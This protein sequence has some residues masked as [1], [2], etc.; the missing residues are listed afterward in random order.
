MNGE[1]FLTFFSEQDLPNLFQIQRD[2]HSANMRQAQGVATSL[3]EVKEW[4][5]YRM[6]IQSSK[7]FIMGVRLVTTREI[8]G[9]VTLTGMEQ[10]L[11]SAEIGIV[12]NEV[13]GRGKGSQALKKLER[14][15]FG[16]FGYKT[17]IVNVLTI[18]VRALSFFDKH[19]YIKVS[20]N[21]GHVMLKK[22]L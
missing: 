19:A 16:S 8:V 6:R 9:Y 4:L 2:A 3:I 22:N 18:N 1:V 13:T 20:E 7:D 12:M 11:F 14:L 5:R 17:L 10:D 15:A 21:E